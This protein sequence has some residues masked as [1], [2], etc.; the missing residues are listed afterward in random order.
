MTESHAHTITGDNAAIRVVTIDTTGTTGSHNNGIGT[1]LNFVAFHH[2]QGDQAT[3]TAFI[4]Q[5][6]EDKM[7]IETLNLRVL[8]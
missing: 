1:D 7:F 3:C 8:E 2:I 4:N 5:N 6:I